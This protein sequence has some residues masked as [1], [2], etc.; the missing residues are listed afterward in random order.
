[1]PILTNKAMST[2]LAAD[3]ADRYVCCTIHIPNIEQ[4]SMNLYKQ[5]SK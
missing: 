5:V 3:D 1:M 2:L 4:P